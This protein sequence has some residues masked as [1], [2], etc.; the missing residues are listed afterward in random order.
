MY[1]Q[2]TGEVGKQGPVLRGASQERAKCSV[3]L[4]SDFTSKTSLQEGPRPLE[5]WNSQ[6]QERLHHHLSY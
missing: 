2:Q 1:H 4:G 3:H 6:G 5:Q